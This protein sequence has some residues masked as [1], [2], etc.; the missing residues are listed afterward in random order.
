MRQTHHPQWYRPSV[1]RTIRL[2]YSHP[3]NATPTSDDA[4]ATRWRITWPVTGVVA[5]P[6]VL[7]AAVIL[8]AS[9][10]GDP[11]VLMLVAVTAVAA[12]V[13]AVTA[14]WRYGPFFVA[15]VALATYAATSVLLLGWAASCPSCGYDYDTT[16]RLVGVGGMISLTAAVTFALAAIA[17]GGT[18]G[19]LA[20]RR[21]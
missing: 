1:T 17:V 9:T 18:L 15:A 12:A 3:M 4:P 2:P 10:F 7:A 21:R 19:R 8:F 14:R 16:R 13:S 20:W 5:G 6:L 11:L